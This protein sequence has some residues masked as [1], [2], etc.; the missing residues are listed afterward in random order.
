MNQEYEIVVTFEQ[1]KEIM[2]EIEYKP[3]LK[4]RYVGDIDPPSKLRHGYGTY[5]YPNKYF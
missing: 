1:L 5:S 2:G 3:D 4:D